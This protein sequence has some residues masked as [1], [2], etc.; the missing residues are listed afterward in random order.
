MLPK[1]ILFDMD[2]TILRY[3]ITLESAWKEACEISAKDTKSFTAEELL[4]HIN[5][6]REWYWSD[7]ERH[8]IGRL[9]LLK[10]RTS[11]ITMA[12]KKLGCEDEKIAENIATSFSNIIDGTLD[13]FPDVEDTLQQLVIKDVKLA[14]LTNGAGAAQQEK[15]SRFRLNRY[16]N[17][18]LIEGELG[19]GKPDQ[20][21]FKMALSKL[22]IT[23]EQTW[24]V[25]DD[26][27]RDIAGAQT[28]GIYSIWCDY[29]K[30]G[31]QE[32]SK[33]QPDKIIN[34]IT[35]LFSL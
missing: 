32:N 35:E 18:R 27:E 28:A 26:L 12:L 7:P 22:K 6:A 15:I 29:G 23:P 5:I 14:L 13:F 17:V 3:T 21:F 11:F 1:A 10:A 9:N 30:K 2:D 33:V 20:R 31:L 34:N 24:M 8:R 25:G 16:F 19:F 4:H